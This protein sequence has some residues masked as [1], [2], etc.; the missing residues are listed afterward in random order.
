MYQRTLVLVVLL[1]TGMLVTACAQPVPDDDAPGPPELKEVFEEAFLI[2]A[3][4]NAGHFFEEDTVGVALVEKHFNSITAENVMK[5]ESIHPEPGVYDFEAADRFVAFGEEHDMFIVGHT[6]VWHNQ[7]PD[8]VF[9]DE[10]G[11]PVSR[12]VLLAR[13]RDHIQT[14][15]G[16]YRG[17]VD[18]WDV[19]N[20]A[21]NEDGTLR[22]TPWLEIIGED[23]L[24]KAFQFTRDVDPEAELYYNDYS[25][26]NPEKRDG[27]VRLVRTLQEQGVP[28]TGIGMQ[29]HYGLDY[30][31]LE[32]LDASIAAFG[33]V[34]DV[35][36]TE[37]DVAVLP[38]PQQHWGADITKSAEL[39]DELNPY[40][41][42]FPD[43]MQQ[44]LAQRY[45]NF[46]EVFLDHRDVISRVTFWGVTDADSWLNNWPIEGRTSYPLLFD[47]A[48]EPKPAFE[49]VVQAARE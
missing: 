31:P 18:G 35:M 30:P 10:A 15:V 27:A 4:L 6:L 3:A 23:Y 40:T 28:V 32:E 33:E 37:L 14:V 12:D 43:S 36:I 20:E 47:R 21:L 17:R 41:E 25:L 22:E 16:R 39:R 49:A 9:E 13:M 7:T 44:A 42:A 5:W 29:G 46:F 8:W 24:A 2:G 19:V 34:G 45:A 26:F 1:V 38:R 48:G 11:N